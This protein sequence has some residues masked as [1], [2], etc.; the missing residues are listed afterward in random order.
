MSGEVTTIGIP[1]DESY[2]LYK[3]QVTTCLGK[4]RTHIHLQQSLLQ[5]Y[6]LKHKKDALKLD[7]PVKQ[8]A[9]KQYEL[10]YAREIYGPQWLLVAYMTQD[11]KIQYHLFT[12]ISATYI[13]GMADE[14]KQGYTHNNIQCNYAMVPMSATIENGS[15]QK[16]FEDD[17]LQAYGIRNSFRTRVAT[18]AIR[19]STVQKTI[20]FTQWNNVNPS[21]IRRCGELY[22]WGFDTLPTVEKA[23]RVERL[24]W[25]SLFKEARET[26]V[27]AYRVASAAILGSP[28]EFSR[29]I[30]RFMRQP[31]WRTR[32]IMPALGLLTDEQREAGPQPLYYWLRP[33]VCHKCMGIKAYGDILEIVMRGYLTKVCWDDDVS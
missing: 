33:D 9:L 22:I 3:G 4:M 1:C 12:Y 24:H 5:A 17:T 31:N 13:Q 28:I 8:L 16:A 6:A 18:F 30:S 32:R 10:K 2:R 11:Y 27:S 15:T 19:S 7:K 20:R 29:H 14:D 25:L 21:N 23:V 26:K